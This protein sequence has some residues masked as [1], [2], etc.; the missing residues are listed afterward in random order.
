MVN[1]A[2]MRRYPVAL[3][4]IQLLL[5]LV[6]A[7]FVAILG[8]NPSREDLTLLIIYMGVTGGVCTLSVFAL[9]RYLINRW[10][11]S[12]RWSLILIVFITVIIVFANVYGTAQLMFINYHDLALTTVLLLFG[13]GTAIICG[14]FIA[15]NLNEKI[16][17]ISR[18][19]QHLAT[20]N[21]DTRLPLDG[22]DELSR[23]AQQMN[24]LADNL[25]EIER[26]KQ[27]VE[28]TRRDLIA[29]VSHDL[30]T[31][32]TAIRAQLEAISDGVVD[33]P[34]E[35]VSY[36]NNSL[37]EVEN[38]KLLIDD[39]FEMSRIDAGHIDLKFEPASLSD[40]ISDTVSSLRPQAQ[41][42]D[43][44][45]RGKIAPN[46]DPVEMAS[47]KNSACIAQPCRKR[48]PSHPTK[49]HNHH[50]RPCKRQPRLCRCPQH[51][52]IY[53]H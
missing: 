26:Q 49:G 5:T 29:W 9:H 7:V 3:L 14:L 24:W 25:Q 37:T 18:S 31:P 50:S 19:I 8:L 4:M 1:T 51:R 22:Q 11:N 43:I 52:L 28:Q 23:L 34:N 53:Q 40:L 2:P 39:L 12:L 15:S 10:M 16:G 38:L 27:I 20:G 36:V 48:H 33:D 42:C 44:A 17:A 13:G 30:R 32:L 46:I 6:L 35:V 41:R 45:I 21:L 47:D